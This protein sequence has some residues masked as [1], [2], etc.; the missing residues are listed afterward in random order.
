MFTKYFEVVK[1]LFEAVFRNS[2]EN[3]R[4]TDYL[5]VLGFTF[6][7]IGGVIVAIVMLALIV[8]LPVLVYKKLTKKTHE[9]ITEYHEKIES[10]KCEGALIGISK[11]ENTLKIKRI[12]FS[13]GVIFVYV[14]FV[15]P[16]LLFIIS[17]ISTLF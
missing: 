1:T 5:Y 10:G 12:C 9:K 15:I 16:T 4:F 13:V 6:A 2:G 7:L 14:P 8:V 11:E 3:I 17:K